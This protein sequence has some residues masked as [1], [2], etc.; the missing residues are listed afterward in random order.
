MNQEKLSKLEGMRRTA[1]EV[2]SRVTGYLRPV[3]SWNKG[4]KEEFQARNTYKNI[5]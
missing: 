4:K 5:K 3:K 1:C 2:W